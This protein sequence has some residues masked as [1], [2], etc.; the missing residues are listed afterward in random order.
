M[1]RQACSNNNK[2]KMSRRNEKKSLR[3]RNNQL[4]RQK[5]RKL[6][7]TSVWFSEDNP[8]EELVERNVRLFSNNM[9]H[10]SKICCK[11]EKYYRAKENLT[12]PKSQS[13]LED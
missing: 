3:R 13:D 2:T 7:R 10:C 12:D 5:V 9:K 6:M 11:N 4:K 1:G 8:S